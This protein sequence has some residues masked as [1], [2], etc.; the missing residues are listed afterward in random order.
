MAS[1]SQVGGGVVSATATINKVREVGSPADQMEAL[2]IAYR[3]SSNQEAFALALIGDLVCSAR[4]KRPGLQ[5][6]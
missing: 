4:N 2:L 5:K 3:L 1:A 6:S